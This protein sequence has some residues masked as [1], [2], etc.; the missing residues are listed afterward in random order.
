MDTIKT[1]DGLEADILDGGDEALQVSCNLLN[2]THFSGM[3]PSIS[4]FAVS[5][6]EQP[7]GKPLHAIALKTENVPDL[8]GIQS[9]WV[10]LVH[11][12]YCDFPFVAQLLLHE[13]T[14]VLLPDENP[15]HSETFWA[16]LREKWEVD[17][18][19]VMGVGLNADENPRG[20]TK[21]HLDSLALLR[22]FGL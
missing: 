4:V 16:T 17:M 6:L 18:G 10:V 15:C 3:L 9:T 13:M 20:L 21:L 5:R 7:N 2:Q 14:H 19:L 12:N 11:K 22:K 8:R 1:D